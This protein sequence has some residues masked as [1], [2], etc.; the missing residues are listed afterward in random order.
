M[1]EVQQTAFGFQKTVDS[2]SRSP[3]REV[4]PLSCVYDIFRKLPDN[5]PIW[6]EAVEGLEQAKNRLGQLSSQIPGQ[7]LVYDTT[8]RKFLEL[9]EEAL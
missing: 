5:S 2:V 8:N 6:I 3:Y 1:S 9:F 4:H 7:Y